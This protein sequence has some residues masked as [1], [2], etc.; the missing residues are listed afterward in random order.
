MKI[1]YPVLQ[2]KWAHDYRLAERLKAY[3]IVEVLLIG[4]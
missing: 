2:A 1:C 3:Q 4:S